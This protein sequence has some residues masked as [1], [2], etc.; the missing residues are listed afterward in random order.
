MDDKKVKNTRRTR[1]STNRKPQGHTAT[2]RKRPTPTRNDRG[3][4]LARDNLSSNMRRDIFKGQVLE[5][6]KGSRKKVDYR[7]RLLKDKRIFLIPLIL[8]VVFLASSKINSVRKYQAYDVKWQT[9][10]KTMNSN[11]EVFADGILSYNKDG[12]SLLDSKGAVVWQKAY[13][14]NMP[15]LSI[16]GEYAVIYDKEGTVFHV[17]NADGCI[18]EGSANRPILKAVIASQGVVATVEEENTGGYNYIQY[19]NK[20]GSKLDIELRTTIA[21]SG[22]P[23]DID[24]SPNGTELVA[25]YVYMDAGMVSN[26][27]T[28]Y[29][30]DVGKSDPQRMVGTFS[31]YDQ[32]LVPQVVFLGDEI[33]AAFGDGRIDFYTLENALKPERKESYSFDNKTVKSIFYDDDYVGVILDSQDS[34]PCELRLYDNS[35]K[36]VLSKEIDFEYDKVKISGENIILLNDT[37]CQ[38]YTLEGRLKY[39]GGFEL[40]GLLKDVVLVSGKEYLVS[41]S[42]LAEVIRFK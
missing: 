35:G 22:Y 27:I 34:S 14:M 31:D 42:D 3:A 37:S 36:E 19:Y 24:I 7:H 26:R 39:D 38:I 9:A 21:D 16:C 10:Q 40:D 15:I 41:T 33:A 17:Y 23:L 4:L 18:G 13:T 11:Y 6:G 12:A 29:N 1:G 20:D 28:F 8:F 5:G 30:F 32:I 2:H 25:S